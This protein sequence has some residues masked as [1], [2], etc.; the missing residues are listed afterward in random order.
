MTIVIP[1]R[2]NKDIPVII[3]RD[4]STPSAKVDA[5]VLMAN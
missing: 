5:D 4:K 2:K 3:Y 1:S